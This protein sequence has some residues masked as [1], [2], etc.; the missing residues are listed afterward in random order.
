MFISREEFRNSK[1][2]TQLNSH[3][4]LSMS[5]QSLFSKEDFQKPIENTNILLIYY[6]VYLLTFLYEIHE[7]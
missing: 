5:M 2:T 6:F 1:P 7:N 4:L 3:A